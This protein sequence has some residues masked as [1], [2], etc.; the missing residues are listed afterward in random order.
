MHVS[1]LI[2]PIES[3][4]GRLLATADEVQAA[5]RR[6]AVGVHPAAP[7]GRR[8]A[9]IGWRRPYAAVGRTILGPWAIHRRRSIPAGNGSR[10]SGGL[11]TGAT[12]RDA[13]RTSRP[14]S[15]TTGGASGTAGSTSATTGGASG[16]SGATNPASAAAGGVPVPAGTASATTGGA[17]D[18]ACVASTTAGAACYAGLGRTVRIR[19]ATVLAGGA[20]S[21]GATSTGARAAACAARRASDGARCASDGAGLPA[22]AEASGGARVAAGSPRT[23]CAGGSTRAARSLIVTRS[24]VATSRTDEHGGSQPHDGQ[25]QRPI[26]HVVSFQ[27]ADS[28]P[29][30][31]SSW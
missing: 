30:L 16:T 6:P 11:G 31:R 7:T 3:G 4:G 25:L 5:A 21:S 8:G 12:V 10:V 19:G 17:A 14:A 27:G 23:G 26:G 20:A 15:A 9:G 22:T 1:P 29:A 13:P 24:G 28:E 2:K 18:R